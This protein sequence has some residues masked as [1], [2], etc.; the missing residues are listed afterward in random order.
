MASVDTLTLES[1]WLPSAELDRLVSE[2][3]QDIPGLSVSATGH[4]A[5]RGLDPTVA[6]ALISGL[7]S[8]VIPFVTKLAERVFAKEPKGVVTISDAGGQDQVV[9]KTT[10]PSD[11]RD[12]LVADALASGALRVRISLEPVSM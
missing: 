6:V 5:H 9:L 7:V 12:Q 11:V 2:C 4:A 3:R 8:I 10:V 1:D